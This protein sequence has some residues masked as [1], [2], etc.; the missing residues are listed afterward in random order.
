MLTKKITSLLSLVYLVPGCIPSACYIVF[1]EY[2][3]FNIT[4]V[5]FSWATAESIFILSHTH[6]HPTPDH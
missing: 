3:L 2:S 6:F 1:V 5:L 4:F